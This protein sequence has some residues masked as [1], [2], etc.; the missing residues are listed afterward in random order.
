VIAGTCADVRKTDGSVV[1]VG[2]DSSALTLGVMEDFPYRSDRSNQSPGANV[3]AYTTA[4]GSDDHKSDLYGMEGLRESFKEPGRRGGG[5]RQDD[6]SPT[7]PKHGH[8]P[9]AAADRERI[10]IMVFGRKASDLRFS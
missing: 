4:S 1:E 7:S 8:R 3:V 6:F 5:S 9:P 2:E 10:T